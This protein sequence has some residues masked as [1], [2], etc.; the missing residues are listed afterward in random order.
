[1][2]ANGEKDK[3][4]KALFHFAYKSLSNLKTADVVVQFCFSLCHC[5]NFTGTVS[6]FVV[7]SAAHVAVS[8]P[9]RLSEFTLTGPHQPDGPLGSYADFTFYAFTASFYRS[10]SQN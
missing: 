5:H 10:F 1:M 8:E 4:A 3:S 7:I 6:P 2:E 9:C